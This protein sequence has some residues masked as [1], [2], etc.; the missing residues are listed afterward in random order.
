MKQINKNFKGL[1]EYLGLGQAEFAALL[2]V[3][4]GHISMIEAGKRSPSMDLFTRACGVY[5]ITPTRLSDGC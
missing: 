2:D 3:T 4:P 1:R 5:H